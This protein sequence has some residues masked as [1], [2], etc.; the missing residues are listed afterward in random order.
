MLSAKSVPEAVL[1]YY[2]KMYVDNEAD[3]NSTIIT[4][5]GITYTADITCRYDNMLYDIEFDSYEFHSSEDAIYKDKLRDVV[6]KKHGYQIIRMRNY[7]K[8]K[9]MPDLPNAINIGFPL[10]FITSTR[11][12]PKWQIIK[13]NQGI[14]KLLQHIG[15][16]SPDISIERDY[17][18]ILDKYFPNTNWKHIAY[19]GKFSVKN[20]VFWN[21][22]GA[23][24]NKCLSLLQYNADVYIVAE[25]E[26]PNE[27]SFPEEFK[28]NIWIGERKT[29]GLCAFGKS[30][31][32]LQKENWITGPLRH[33]LPFTANGIPIVGV[34]AGK[35]YI[36]EYFIWQSLNI[37]KIN[38]K[39]II[40][41]DFNSNAKWDYKHGL[42]N[43]TEVVKQLHSKGLT[44]AYHILNKEEYGD[45]CVSTF[46]QYRHLDRGYHI[47][48]AFC[49]SQIISEFH[50][51][52]YKDW[53][54][55][56]DHTPLQLILK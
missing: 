39:T 15:I 36:E 9:S 1:H 18:Y 52:D 12:F 20:I 8:T 55:L 44:S 17:N 42:R 23:F 31:V 10:N 5:N 40:I 45:E 43:H 6:F 19:N 41:G 3:L 16:Q 35:P 48:Y 7:T 54:D 53:R 34:W 25:C 33:F 30:N 14:T 2:I 22:N 50:I 32:F 37:D 13:C 11:T 47:D 46:F 29:K 38:E 49:N 21:A 4:E 28:N 26:N 24:R 27:Y 51:A 56:S